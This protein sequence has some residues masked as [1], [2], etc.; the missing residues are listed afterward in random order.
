MWQKCGRTTIRGR[1]VSAAANEFA[2]VN[3]PVPT[4]LRSFTHGH[5]QQLDK[6]GAGLL[7]GPAPG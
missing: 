4:F 3:R 7:T 5:V 2:Q 1:S 6:I